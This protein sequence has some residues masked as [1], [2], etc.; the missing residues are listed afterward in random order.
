MIT[1]REPTGWCA[2]ATV[3]KA[4]AG[5]SAPCEA[6]AWVFVAAHMGTDKLCCAARVMPEEVRG[7][8]RSAATNPAVRSR[9]LYTTTRPRSMR[10]QWSSRCSASW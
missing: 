4:L 1:G 10:G 3:S 9:Q 5:S 7:A 6:S 8:T 2:P